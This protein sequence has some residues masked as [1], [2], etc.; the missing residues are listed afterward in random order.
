MESSL[1]GKVALVTGGSRGIGRATSL[2]LAAKGATV[3]VNYVR[4]ETSANQVVQAIEAAGGRAMPV[5]ADVGERTA[6]ETMVA[7]I[8]QALGPVDILVNNAGIWRLGSLL[9]HQDD[10]FDDMW[11]TNVKGPVYAAAAVAPDMIERK[12][13]R[14]INV[15]SN[16][17]VGTAMP[18]TTLY[19]ATKAALLVLT[20]R[21]ALELGE[22]RITVNAMLPGYV[23]S[24]MTAR[25][26]S[27]EQ[28][29]AVTESL[30]QRSMLGR[31]VGEPEDIAH[32][33]A[34]VA[35]EESRF[36]TGQ[37]LMADGG[38]IDYLSHV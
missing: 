32:V 29:A 31:G 17:G 25:G 26:R 36:M 38:R 12:W 23:R 21:M 19:A 5:Q 3:A 15:A 28:I 4:D 13:G 34:F 14:I 24:D 1:E 35:S 20:K 37:L 7:S 18:G 22:H 2:A 27:E 9:E 10:D 11:R 6:V 16:A 33:I 8:A 30:N